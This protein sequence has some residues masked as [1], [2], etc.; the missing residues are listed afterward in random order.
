MPPEPG[1]VSTTRLRKHLI[2]LTQYCKTKRFHPKQKSLPF[3]SS[4]EQYG[5]T[6][7]PSNQAAKTTHNVTNARKQ[8]QQNICCVNAKNTLPEFGQVLTSTLIEY[9]GEHI[10]TMQLTHREII[11]NA[12]YPSIKIHV[13]GSSLRGTIE[14]VMKSKET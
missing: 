8:K 11:F 3:K 7:K 2:M 6:I 9:T 13:K 14:H 5:Q 4:T 1:M 10:P 12:I